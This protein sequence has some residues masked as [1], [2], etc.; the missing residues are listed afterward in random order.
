M[1][2]LCPYI[3]HLKRA[4]FTDIRDK[5]INLFPLLLLPTDLVENYDEKYKLRINV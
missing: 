1:V 4:G 2:I 3:Q 5:L